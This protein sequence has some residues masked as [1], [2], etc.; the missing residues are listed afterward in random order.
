LYIAD[1][2]NER[3]RR[4]ELALPPAIL[5]INPA[6]GTTESHGLQL[7]QVLFSR[8][9]ATATVTTSTFQLLDGAANPVAPLGIQLQNDDQLVEL[10][11][12]P[13][14]AGHYQLVIDAA[15]VT[16]RFGTPLG[17]AP[18]RS[19]FTLFSPSVT[20]NEPITT[21]AGNGT[22]GYSGDGGPATQAELNIPHGVALGPDGTLYIA[23]NVV[24]RRVAPDGIITTVAGNGTSGYSGDGGPATQAEL[25]SPIG[26]AVGPDGSLYIADWGNN[27]I[28]RV[29]PDGVITTVA[30][31]G[32]GGD[33]GP[34]TQAALFEPSAVAVGP[35][36]SLY[37]PDRNRIRRVGPD[38]IITTV[39]GG[40]SQGYSGDG[41][42]ATLAELSFPSGVAIGP[43]GS[44][45]IADGNNRIRRVGP[46]GVITTVAGNGTI[47]FS[48][49]GGPATQAELGTPFGVAVGPD[50]LLYIADFRNHRIRRVGADGII[51]TVAGDGTGGFSG[52]G[53]PAI[54]SAW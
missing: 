54:A 32:I 12:R 2:V 9:L 35:D 15:A 44:L 53:G 10:N 7:V 21:V 11:Y 22:L 25:N 51:T 20:G 41:G 18:V 31:G 48:G 24:V 50:G 3:I 45:Y 46:D 33:G 49:D 52:D 30:G 1:V 13:L 5:S 42:P 19:R 8:Q 26:V 36:G 17:A 16:D 39:A 47:G 4:V 27:R 28:R 34:A 29:G 6:D 38:G 37:I 14:P 43:D 23:D 40:A